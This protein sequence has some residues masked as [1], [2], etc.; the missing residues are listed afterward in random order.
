MSNS[1]PFYRRPGCLLILVLLAIL[2]IP[3]GFVAYILLS[4]AFMSMLHIHT[5]ILRLR[6][7]TGA[8]TASVAEDSVEGPMAGLGEDT[9]NVYLTS[10]RHPRETDATELLEYDIDDYHDDRPRIAWSAPNVLR[11]TVPNLS[12]PAI[13]ALHLDGVMVDLHYDP[14]DPVA[15][16]KWQKHLEDVDKHVDDGLK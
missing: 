12:L 13:V 14:D 11:V 16:A 10:K 5:D 7:P 15:R 3:F 2:G 9:W 8:L 4:V 6:S 1:L